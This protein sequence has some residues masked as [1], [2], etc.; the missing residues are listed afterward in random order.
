MNHFAKRALALALA[1]LFTFTLSAGA[2]AEGPE[3]TEGAGE[4]NGYSGYCYAIH[5]TYLCSVYDS[6]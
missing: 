1:L 2:L 6:Q 4:C 5:Y 3:G